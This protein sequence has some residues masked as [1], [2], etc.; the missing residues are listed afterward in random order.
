MATYWHLVETIMGGIEKMREAGE[1]YLPKFVAESADAYRNRIKQARMTNVFLDIIQNLSMRPFEK[2]VT[3]PEETPKELVEFAEDVDGA[4]NNLHVFAFA[5]FRAAMSRGITF[6]LVDYTKGADKARTRAEEKAMGARPFWRHYLAT[7]VVAIYSDHINGQEVL[8]EVRL[9]EFD[10][11][12][13]GFSEENVEKIRVFRLEMETMETDRYVTWE[14]YERDESGMT[15]TSNRR[16]SGMNEDAL[17]PKSEKWNLVEGPH[18]L[19]LDYIPLVPIPFSERMDWRV[20]PPLK[21][22]AHLQIEL[23]Q[24]ENGLKNARIA[25]AYP[26]LAGQ[27]VEPEKEGGQIKPIIVGPNVV[28]YGGRG[29]MDSQGGRWEYIEP[30]ATSLEFLRNDIRDTKQDLRELGRQPLTA[31]SPNIT[32]ISAAAA[33]KKGDAAIHAWVNMLVNGLTMA[34]KYTS[35]WLDLML[36][37]PVIPVIHQDFDL[38]PM[39]DD[40]F[41]HVEKMGSG[42]EPMISRETVIDEAKRRGILRADYDAEAD[43]KRINRMTDEGEEEEETDPPPPPEDGENETE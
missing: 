9:R 39:G 1:T 40:T 21:D 19:S 35:D 13:K 24:Q 2:P 5:L 15:S 18:K 12:R 30:S 22:A 31:Q 8:T 7:D 16:T 32:A 23:Y 42:S 10:I 3:L 14:V 26:M 11:V 6:L 28:L 29:S 41:T 33:S 43:L 36:L 37:K 20:D 38:Q 25:T 34:F 27:G 17:N 4:G